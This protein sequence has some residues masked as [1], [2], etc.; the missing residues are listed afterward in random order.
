MS[1]LKKRFGQHFLHDIAVLRG[2][3]DVCAAVPGDQTVEIGPGGGALTA[4]LLA[5]FGTLHAIEIDRDLVVDLGQYFP[6][7]RL[8]IHEAD[9]LRFPICARIPGALRV[10]GNLPYNISSPLIFHLLDQPRIQSMVFLLQKEV[11]DRLAATPGGHDY[12]RLSVMVQAVCEVSP[13]FTVPASAFTPP[14]QVE[15]RLVY[16][17][18]IPSRVAAA[19]AGRFAEIVAVAFSQR[20]K[21]LRHNLKRYFRDGDWKALGI[22]P[23][24]RAETL[25]IEEFAALAGYE[26]PPGDN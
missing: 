20:R 9:V 11:V 12:G 15:S 14:P 18:P 4:H 1:A 26:A 13:L 6:A 22:D 10:V 19:H 23:T 16:L 17:R 3:A 5:R 2:I 7:D 8:T 24:R 21:M 25:T